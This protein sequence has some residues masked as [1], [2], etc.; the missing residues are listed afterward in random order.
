MK[1]KNLAR[2]TIFATISGYCI[3]LILTLPF[4]NDEYFIYFF[5][6]FLAGIGAVVSV[7][8]FGIF[9]ALTLYK[10]DTINDLKISIINGLIASGITGLFA[11][12]MMNEFDFNLIIQEGFSQNILFPLAGMISAVLGILLI[13]PNE[14]SLL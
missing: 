13:K 6:A 8:I 9:N 14:I 10:N 5:S 2:H 7:I 11:F 1:T 4:L 12:L 3:Y